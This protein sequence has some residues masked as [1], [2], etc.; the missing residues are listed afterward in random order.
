MDKTTKRPW[1]KLWNKQNSKEKAKLTKAPDL[2]NRVLK[3]SIKVAK[4][5]VDH[6]KK[7]RQL[8]FQIKHEK[9]QSQG[10]TVNFPWKWEVS[11]QGVWLEWYHQS[12]N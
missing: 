8:E 9:V 7:A 10:T 5:C 4:L 6:P 3:E 11:V 2:C 12:M 1:D